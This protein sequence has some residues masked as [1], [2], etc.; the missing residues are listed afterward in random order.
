MHT[1]PQ[2]RCACKH[3]YSVACPLGFYPVDGSCI[4]DSSEYG[5]PCS[6]Y[7]FPAH[8]DPAKALIMERACDTSYPFEQHCSASTSLLSV[9][10]AK[11]PVFNLH[12]EDR[13]R[14]ARAGS[15]NFWKG[16]R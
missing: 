1:I 16:T 9:G 8:L 6:E 13:E 11:Y 5:G 7:P 14:E 2:A 3:D 12:V 4:A 15:S 10:A